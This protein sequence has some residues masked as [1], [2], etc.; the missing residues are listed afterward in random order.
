LFISF[1]FSFLFYYCLKLSSSRDRAG[2]SE[3]ITFYEL[4]HLNGIKD[5]IK[6]KIMNNHNIKDID[7]III[8]EEGEIK[9]KTF[10]K[11]GHLRD[12]ETYFTERKYDIIDNENINT[13]LLD[14]GVDIN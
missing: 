9:D 13:L 14:I 3:K 2:T 4:E 7:N 11:W 12:T 1:Y 6:F 10:E 8:N 5:I